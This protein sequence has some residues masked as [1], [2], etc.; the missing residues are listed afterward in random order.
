MP[1]T[2]RIIW[3]SGSFAVQFGDHFRSGDH[4]RS[5]IICGAVQTSG[6]IWGQSKS[7]RLVSSQKKIWFSFALVSL[8]KMLLTWQYV[9]DTELNMARFGDRVENMRTLFV[10][11]ARASQRGERHWTWVKK[12]CQ[13]GTHSFQSEQVREEN[14]VVYRVLKLYNALLVQT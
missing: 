6:R 4:S 14:I 5:G 1:F 12:S 7:H 10:E 8:M 9:R 11:I 2:G 13:S 3:G